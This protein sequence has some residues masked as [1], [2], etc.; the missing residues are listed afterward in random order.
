MTSDRPAGQADAPKA[1]AKLAASEAKAQYAAASALAPLR[2][3]AR[4]DFESAGGKVI[5]VLPGRCWVV[6]HVLSP[7]ECDEWIQLGTN[8]GMAKNTTYTSELRTNRRTAG[9]VNLD[10]ARVVRERLPSELLDRVEECA[11][12]TAVRSV[13]EEWRVTQY[14]PRELFRPHFDDSVFRGRDDNGERGETSSHTVL[15][16]LSDDFVGGA[17]RF[18][19]QGSYEGAVDVLAPKGSVLIFE[20]RTLLH[21]GCAI[22][23][24]VKFVAQ[25]GLMRAP[26]DRDSV[27][28]KAPQP[29]LFRWGPGLEAF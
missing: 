2:A 10:M 12:G 14:E 25:T 26:S 16:I 5:E 21:E 18:W 6:P 27:D 22:E 17:T 13:Y 19:P 11:P 20:Q 15:V 3:F 7:T 23:S 8:H 4:E 29:V 28:A 9:F 24:G 1:S